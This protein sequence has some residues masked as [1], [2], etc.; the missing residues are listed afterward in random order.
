MNQQSSSLCNL[1]Q[2]LT[3]NT[4]IGSYVVLL[5]LLVLLQVLLVLQLLLLL[6]S[7]CQGKYVFF[8][9][10]SYLFICIQ[11]NLQMNS[12]L[13]VPL[14]VCC[15]VWLMIIEYK[16]RSAA[17]R[18]VHVMIVNELSEDLLYVLLLYCVSLDPFPPSSRT[19]GFQPFYLLF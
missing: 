16:V 15:K 7:N 11:A 18:P 8:S 4:R 3:C 12:R 19:K 9:C 6:H 10:D 2:T 17:A 1:L 14:I 5:L 13:S